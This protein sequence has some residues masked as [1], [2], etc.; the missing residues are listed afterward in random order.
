MM[1]DTIQRGF[2]LVELLVSLSLFTVVVTMSMGTL[3]VLIDAN[4]KAQNM[5][6][7]MTNLTF[8]LDSMTREIRTGR[9]Y[10]CPSTPSSIYSTVPSEDATND[11]TEKTAISIVEGG[12]SLTGAGNPRI[13]YRYID[14]SI[15]RRVGTGAWIP[16]TSNTVTITNMYFTVTGSDGYQATGDTTPPTVTVFIEGTAGD[17]ESVDTSFSVETTITRRLLDI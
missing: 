17:L 15:E 4:A 9:A 6:E 5:Q 16:L 2:T 7:V 13:A 1:R 11:C 14:G 8:A 3:L 10:Y 12:S